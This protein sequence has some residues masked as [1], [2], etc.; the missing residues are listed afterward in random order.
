MPLAI[1][2]SLLYY[3]PMTTTRK[4]LSEAHKAKL[5]KPKGPMSEEHKQKL[6]DA[7]LHYH[8]NRAPQADPYDIS[9]IGVLGPQSEAH[10]QKLSDAMKAYWK[11]RKEAE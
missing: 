2:G 4:P 6:R 7:A 5:R 1:G 3:R 11:K 8:A 10:K 9:K